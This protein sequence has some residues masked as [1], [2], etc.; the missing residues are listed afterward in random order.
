MRLI[1]VPRGE[2]SG[3]SN[4][5][6][7]ALGPIT[8]RP[9]LGG[10]RLL[11]DSFRLFSDAG[12]RRLPALLKKSRDAQPAVSTAPAG[13]ALGA[14]R[15]LLRGL[16]SAALAV[17]HKPAAARPDHLYDGLLAVLM[18]LVFILYAQD[19]DLLPS[20]PDAW[21]QEIYETGNSVRG[22]YAKLVEDAALFPETVD[23]RRGGRGLVPA[24]FRL[25]HKGYNGHFVQARGELFDPDE[26]PV[27]D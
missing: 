12:D 27:L 26:F 10:S 6:L 9:M 15:E 22:L 24:L 11:L 8:G 4:F 7:S 21:G 20:R 2:T 19:R 5:P 1:Y 18:R 25:I 3:H 14:L 16:E 23:E 13:Q 17:I